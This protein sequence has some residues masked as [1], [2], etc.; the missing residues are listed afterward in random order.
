MSSLDVAPP[1]PITPPARRAVA[2]VPYSNYRVYGYLVNDDVLLEYALKS[3]LGTD[4]DKMQRA[5]AIGR[6]AA[7]IAEG[8]G[9]YPCLIAGVYYDGK[10]RTCVAIASEDFHDRM[11]HVD[12]ENVEKLKKM[13][14]TQR[15]P[16]WYTH[17]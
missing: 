10:P 4:D 1:A 8:F 11:P 2:P 3:R 6:A 5:Y 15:P 13:F 17:V 16:I 7:Y 9:V 12:K 14:N